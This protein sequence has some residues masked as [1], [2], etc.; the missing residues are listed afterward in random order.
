M[1]TQ[2]QLEW[3]IVASQ[4]NMKLLKQEVGKAQSMDLARQLIDSFD[5]YASIV[6]TATEAI[7]PAAQLAAQMRDGTVRFVG[8]DEPG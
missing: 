6:A 3:I 8:P 7:S 4:R 1:F 5:T 2:K